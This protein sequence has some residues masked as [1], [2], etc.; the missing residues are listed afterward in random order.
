MKNKLAF[1]LVA[2][3]VVLTLSMALVGCESYKQAALTGAD[4]TAEV[5]SNGG[6]I[7]KQG[8]YLYFINGYAGYQTTRKANAFGNVVTGAIMRVKA[9][10]LDNTDE[11]ADLMA[12]A[13]IVVPKAV[14]S[15]AANTGFSI[16]GNYLYYISYSG[17]ETRSGT[18]DTDRTQ[19]LRTDLNGQNTKVILE[20][21]EG[22]STQYKYTPNGLVYVRDGNLYFKSTATDKFDAAKDGELIAEDVTVS[23][24]VSAAYNPKVGMTLSDAV[25]YTKTNSDLYNDNTQTLYAYMAGSEPIEVLNKDS[26]K[27]LYTDAQQAY[28]YQFS[29]SI[30]GFAT[31]ADGRLTMAYTKTYYNG[32]TS[33]DSKTVG[34]FVYRFDDNKFVFAVSGEKKVSDSALSNVTVVGYQ[35]G[36]VASASPTALYSYDFAAERTAFAL[37]FKDDNGSIASPTICDVQ[38]GW[39]YYVLSNKLYCYK[40]DGKSHVHAIGTDSVYTDFIKPEVL[41]WGGKTRVAFFSNDNKYLYL[42]TLDGSGNYDEVKSVLLGRIVDEDTKAE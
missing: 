2:I 41:S 15:D 5:V 36:V 42:Y 19:F 38:D 17:E 9:A 13:E 22:K 24:P 33:S 4:A 20:I 8:D 39:M 16:Y 18:V 25:L 37:E 10:D 23:M 34:T 32:K 29:Y 21:E 31:E 40:V 35:Q 27:S 14:I 26:Y 30:L 3:V 7:V 11:D 28:K 6:S 12:N 1:F